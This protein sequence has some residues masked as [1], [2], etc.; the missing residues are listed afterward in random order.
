MAIT[1]TQPAQDK[2]KLL[3]KQRQTPDQYLRI[4]LQGG[5]CSGFKYELEFDEN[6]S[7]DDTVFKDTVVTDEQSLEFLNTS[8]VNF[9][10]S[11]MSSKFTVKN[12]KASASCGCGKSFAVSVDD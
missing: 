12:P 8:V 4:G 5:G 9:E 11:L 7:A 10:K 1:M 2:I 3:L 6:V